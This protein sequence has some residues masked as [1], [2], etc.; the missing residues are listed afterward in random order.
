M[1]FVFMVGVL[2]CFVLI[3]V[4]GEALCCRC[5]CTLLLCG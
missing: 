3:C 2:W 1:L 4:M 5:A